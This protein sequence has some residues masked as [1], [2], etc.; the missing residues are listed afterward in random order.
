MAGLGVLSGIPDADGVVADLGGGSLELVD[1]GDGEVRHSASLP[2]GVLRVGETGGKR[3]AALI[4]RFTEAVEA[5]G[6]GKRGRKRPLYMVGGSWRALARV[7]M[8]LT[9]HPLPVMHQYHMSADRPAELQPLLKTVKLDRKTAPSLSISRLPTLPV[10]NL[11]LRT[12]VEAVR[13]SE[14][15]VS[16][17]GIREGLL[18]HDLDPATRA[19]DPLIEAARD[20]GRGLGRF[21][22]H[23]ALLERWIAPI[24][25][26]DP[27][28]ERLRVAACML[29]DVAWQ[30][31]PDFRAERGVDMAL[32]GNWVGI[33]APGRVMLAQALFANFG[34]SGS[35]DEYDVAALCHP[36]ELK[37]ATRWGLAMRLGQRL[38]GGVATSL[39]RSQL[40]LTDGALRLMLQSGEQELYGEA[41]DR[42]LKTL[43]GSLGRK[44]EVFVC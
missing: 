18:Y 36:D 41:V 13:P 39:E 12:L 43:A 20:A 23:G 24:F 33:D 19:R 29:A 3:E 28:A 38:S 31:H 10:A 17:F 44:A 35:F 37:Q 14:L 26:D 30:A 21:E 22:E 34:G 5:A 4:R 8:L 1:V 2:F 15:V 11:L 40:S 7:D 16:S 25:D 32:H 27:W 9:G 42:R 6:F